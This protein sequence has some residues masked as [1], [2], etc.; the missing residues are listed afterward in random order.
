[1]GRAQRR[2]S[3]KGKLFICRED[4]HAHAAFALRSRI[5]RQDERGFRE[6]R[7]FGQ[8]LH[9][10]IRKPTAVGEDGQLVSFQRH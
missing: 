6:I 3:G 8:R 10:R 5:A 4:A 1:M 7:L 9:L 2:V